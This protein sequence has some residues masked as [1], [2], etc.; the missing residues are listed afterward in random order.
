MS[1]IKKL[2]SQT[3]YY[4]LSSVIGRML[5]FF[6]IPLHTRKLQNAEL[7]FIAELYSYA[8][9]LNILYIFGMELAYFRFSNLNNKSIS[10]NNKN[11]IKSFSSAF[12]VTLFCSLIISFFLILFAPSLVYYMRHKN[13]PIFI[14]YLSLIMLI[15]GLTAIPMASLRLEN[16]AKRFAIIQLSK[17]FILIFF[18]FII[19][20][21]LDEIYNGNIFI[22]FQNSIKRFYNPKNKIEYLL[23]ANIISSLFNFIIISSKLKNLKLP[24][25]LKLTI[26][27]IKYS[28]PL[29]F[30]GLLGVSNEMFLRISIK[31]LI[32]VNPYNNGEA[33]LGIF[34]S[35]FKLSLLMNLCIQAYRYAA[36]PFFFSESNKIGYQKKFSLVM[37]IFIITMCFFLF[38]ISINIDIISY[39]MLG[40]RFQKGVE[41][42]PYAMLS[43]LF[44]G[45]YYNIS[46]WFKIIRKTYFAI[47]FTLISFIISLSIILLLVPKIGY[48]GSIIAFIFSSLSMVILS[49]IFG[50]KYYP[51]PYK[52]KECITLILFT[53]I[54]I[55]IIRKL[56]PDEL[57]LKFI[58][59]SIL[60]ILSIFALYLFYKK[61]RKNLNLR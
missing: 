39:L 3:I 26:K 41:I 8:A 52:L 43:Y 10:S 45:I 38:I 4:G 42:V 12:I 14:Y 23:L 16:K 56:M 1:S 11:N 29:V 46:S 15:D 61:T 48:W 44:L 51:I 5:H 22:N 54:S 7:G 27:M 21:L 50:Q 30:V 13:Q 49:Y 19:L 34:S 37:Y 53:I 58:Y 36:E 32:P 20:Y 25:N 47:Y 57:E 2:A 24:I 28:I 17:I 59:G 31:Y 9:V 35:C 18:N 60:S 33:I 6:I 55:F 40:P